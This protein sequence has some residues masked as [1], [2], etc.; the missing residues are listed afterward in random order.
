ME[1]E[2]QADA[3]IIALDDVPQGD[4]PDDKEMAETEQQ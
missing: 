3:T 1:L 2:S 4:A